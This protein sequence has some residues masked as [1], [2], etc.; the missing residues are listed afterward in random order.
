MKKTLVILLSLIMM[1]LLFTGCKKSEPKVE[2]VVDIHANMAQSP[3]TGEWIDEELAAKRP[4]AIMINN[5]IDAQPMSGISKA[6]IIYEAPVEYNI[7]RCLAI[8]QDYS[9]LEKIGSVRSCR[10][11]YP[12]IAS[13]YDAIYVHFGASNIGEAFLSRGTV[14]HLDGMVDGGVFY[15]ASDRKAPHNAFTSSDGI[16]KGIENKK[17]ETTL[18][19]D[20]ENPLKFN[21]DDEKEI[22]LTDGEE[23]LRVDTNF[24][25]SKPYFEYNTETKLYDRY[26]FNAAH[27]D[28][29]NDKQLTFKNLIVQDCDWYMA[30]GQHKHITTTGNG[31]GKYYTNG[32]SVNITWSKESDL[33]RTSF[34]YEDGSELILNQGKTFISIEIKNW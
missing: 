14:D 33:G 15:R 18:E 17:Y 22:E 23:A 34:H 10:L 12:L 6:D 7:S 5:I 2:E 4:V 9:D 16:D 27:V 29:D 28:A 8:F 21:E 1:M 24:P 32:K 11:H 25:H 19:S 3:L 20:F 13:E 26:Q 30:D 31:T